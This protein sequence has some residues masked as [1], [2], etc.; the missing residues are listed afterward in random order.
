M[1]KFIDSFGKTYEITDNE[2][3]ENFIRSFAQRQQS[4][5]ALTQLIQRMNIL[6]E[7]QSKLKSEITALSMDMNEIKSAVNNIDYNIRSG[8]A[9]RGNG[10]E[11]STKV[12][13]DELAMYR[14]DL[15]RK[16]MSRYIADS[17]LYLYEQ[18]AR[19]IHEQNGNEDLERVLNLMRQQLRAIGLESR[20]SQQNDDFDPA[21]MEVSRYPSYPTDN[22]QLDG[23][24]AKSLVPEF[25]WS[26]TAQEAR[27]ERLMISKEKVIL[28][29]YKQPNY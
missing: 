9:G 22:Q 16:L 3:F 28:Y 25:S 8:N 5:M 7:Q 23:R 21:R 4:E 19:Q 12:L 13:Q 20:S 24:I 27:P 6:Q 18:I 26:A 14:D 11:Q 2:A 1:A 17:Q 29:E 10:D 15:H